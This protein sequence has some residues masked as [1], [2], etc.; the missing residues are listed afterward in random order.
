MKQKFKL[1][2]ILTASIIGLSTLFSCGGNNGGNIKDD[3]KYDEFG[4][5]IF[6]NVKLNVLSI[7]GNPDNTYL[8][9]VNNMFNDYYSQNGLSAKITSVANSD[10]YTQLAN[11]INTDP[12]NA[13]DVIIIHSERVSKL[14]NDKIILPMDSY[15][16]LLKNNKFNEEDYFSNVLKE[17]KYKDK[18]YGIPLDVHSGVWYYRKDIL[19]KN[20]I[21]I[22]TDLN[23]FIK[24]CNELIKKY[25]A[26]ELF[27]RAMDKVNS[28]NCEWTLTRDF[29][30][31]YSPV[32]MSS[33]GGIEAGWIPQTAV[34]QNGGTLTDESG[35][36][37]WNTNGLKE[38][39]QLLRDFQTGTNSLTNRNI[40]YEGNFVSDDND[41]N[42]VWSKLSS[43]E[44]VFS[45]EG[46]WWAESRL[47]EYNSVLANREDLD[48]NKYQPLGILN[49]SKLYTFDQDSAYSKSIYGVGHCF[50]ICKTVKSKTKLVAASLYSKFMS[51]NSTDYL[52]GG[53][54]PANKKVYNSDQFRSKDY[55]KD[56]VQYLGNPEDYK[57]LGNT[58]H[59]SAVYETLKSL[60]MDVFTKSKNNISIDQLVE[61]RF[62]EAVEQIKS[63]E[64]L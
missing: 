49:M 32:V 20:N 12:D 55:Y 33:S 4:D 5:P 58:S 1:L 19:E 59:Y 53:H 24:C 22:P 18:L 35:Y 39:M 56:Y 41:Y 30:K 45:C 52:Q 62:K 54:L 51:E 34:F 42:T 8:E 26:G 16:D 7:V 57:M 47:N 2:T 36:P 37:K 48:G 10:F 63:T 11:T 13:P 43:G 17:C 21:E 38:I 46:P 6:D 9:R 28:T 31:S 25:K 64:E 27:T 60:Y 23:S 61:T 50:S 44:A 14:A 15:F 29:G 3:L 40:S